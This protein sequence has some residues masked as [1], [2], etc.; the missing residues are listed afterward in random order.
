MF[1]HNWPLVDTN[2]ICVRVFE[3][4]EF[5]NHYD[6]QNL[7]TVEWAKEESFIH[8]HDFNNIPFFLGDAISDKVSSKK[9]IPP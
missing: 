1:D 8:M 4:Q 7:G 3:L 9:T 2:M 5:R 6:L